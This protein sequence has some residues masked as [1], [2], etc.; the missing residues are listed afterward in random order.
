M[1]TF[2]AQPPL[3]DIPQD[4]LGNRIAEIDKL[5]ERYQRYYLT[6]FQLKPHSDNVEVGN[7]TIHYLNY[8][9][10]FFKVYSLLK[11]SS[12]I[13]IHSLYYGWR[14]FPHFFFIP[15]GKKK[16]IYE[17]HGIFPEEIEYFGQTFKSKLFRILE[18]TLCKHCVCLVYVSQ[19]HKQH[20]N[21]K[22]PATKFAKDFILPTVPKNA[23]V[24]PD[25]DKVEE[26]K[27][28]IG[29]QPDDVVF[30]YS[31]NTAKWQKLPVTLDCIKRIC[32]SPNYKFIILTQN[33][34]EMKNM[35]KAWGLDI[36]DN[37]YLGSVPPS[38]LP[39]YYA[40]G[41]YGF[42]IRDDH[43]VNRVASPTKLFEYLSYGIIPI[44]D[45]Y[46]IGD[47][48]NYHYEAIHYTQLDTN[49]P[50][51]KSQTNIQ[52]AKSILSAFEKNISEYQKYIDEL[53]QS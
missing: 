26:I 24:E 38:E 25:P 22:Y 2:I 18:S 27:K 14:I 31:G 39:Y 5:F 45:L 48:G 37:I 32:V 1:I 13:Y 47:F 20:F 23:F 7:I 41:H 43:I 33:Y 49:L 6:I 19:R 8:I 34:D 51:R 11:K 9:G 42:I 50:Q 40:L 36:Y 44:V 35:L 15:K 16:I 52:V 28:S 46:E 3:K 17:P 10:N 29:I 21:S 30:L 4:G 53:L 12:L